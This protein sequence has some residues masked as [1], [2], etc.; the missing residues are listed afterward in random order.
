[1]KVGEQIFVQTMGEKARLILDKDAFDARKVQ[2]NAALRTRWN[3][4]GLPGTLIFTHPE[5]QEVEVMLDQESL[6]WGRSLRE[7][8]QATLV[9]ATPVPVV[10]KKLRPWRERTQLLL[11]LAGF[12]NSSAQPTLTAGQRLFLRL[13]QPP[14]ADPSGYPPGLNK[15]QMATERVEWIMATIYCTCGMHDACA[16]HFYTLAACDAGPGH[17]CHSAANHQINRRR[18]NRSTN[19]GPSSQR[20]R[21]KRVETAHVALTDSKMRG[22][23]TQS[24][25]PRV[26]N[27]HQANSRWL[28]FK[29]VDP[30]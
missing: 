21:T 22:G 3:N 9:S 4:E 28:A 29:S 26:R 15:S 13:T 16:G 5:R 6:E 14:S 8:D 12:D 11:G 27:P 24:L 18:S 7:G 1:L 23:R 19:H 17:T 25:R 30:A 2:Q 20:A 10:V